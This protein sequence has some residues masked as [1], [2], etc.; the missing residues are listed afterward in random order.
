MK[1]LENKNEMK[2]DL[3]IWTK[4]KSTCRL[5][6]V[7]TDYSKLPLA[8]GSKKDDMD[9]E[10]GKIKQQRCLH[11]LL[12][13]HTSSCAKPGSPPPLI[14]EDQEIENAHFFLKPDLVLVKPCIRAVTADADSVEKRSVEQ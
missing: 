7:A 14:C 11:H 1:N 5:R 3:R 4:T 9:K 6:C 8:C 2:S 12:V 10:Q 13:S